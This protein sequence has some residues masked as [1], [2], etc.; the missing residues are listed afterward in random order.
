MPTPT[1]PS[2]LYT[3]SGKR[4]IDASFF[5]EQLKEMNSHDPFG[6]TFSDMDIVSEDLRGLRSG[7]KFKCRM[8][9]VMKTVWTSRHPGTESNLNTEAVIAIMSIGGGYSNL[10]ELCS[11]MDIPS[12]SQTTYNK[13]HSKVCDAWEIAAL[14][15]ME[16]A[17]AEEKQLAIDRGD[18]DI[19]GVPYFA[20]VADGSWAKRSYKTNYSSLSGMVCGIKFYPE[21]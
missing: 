3:I 5:F 13:E 15:S 9:H 14:K 19:E 1:T 10:V 18:V 21:R 20:V 2:T 4:I 8:C 16:D 12:M 11:S 17:A 6:C 7:I